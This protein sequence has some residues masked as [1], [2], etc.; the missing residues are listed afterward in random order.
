MLDS[1]TIRPSF[2]KSMDLKNKGLVKTVLQSLFMK[3]KIKT[4]NKELQMIR[5]SG[6]PH[7][8][9]LLLSTELNR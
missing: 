7:V 5:K 2:L 9:P 3:H 1:P 4:Q 8:A 6:A